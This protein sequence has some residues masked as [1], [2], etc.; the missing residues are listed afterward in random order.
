LHDYFSVVSV[1]VTG[2]FFQLQGGVA[3][4]FSVASG[5]SIEGVLQL[6]F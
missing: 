2:F 3:I 5:V 6:G 1:V 4:E